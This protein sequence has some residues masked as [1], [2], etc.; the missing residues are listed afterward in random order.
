MRHIDKD[1]VDNIDTVSSPK[2]VLS[3]FSQKMYPLLLLLYIPIDK[4]NDRKKEIRMRLA[5]SVR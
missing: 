4:D 2:C 5:R 3:F 1:I